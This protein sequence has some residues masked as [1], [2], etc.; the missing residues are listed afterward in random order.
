M[1]EEK[2]SREEI[3]EELKAQGI[4]K[5]NKISKCEWC[6]KP[7]GRK[8]GNQKTCSPECSRQM[9]LKK[10]RERS[11]KYQIKKTEQ[12][13]QHPQP[14]GDFQLLLETLQ[15]IQRELRI[16]NAHDGSLDGKPIIER[17]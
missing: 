16:R 15:G 3:I 2:Y 1:D 5:T 9:H 4:L 7:Y 14:K 6:G 17:E 11:Y 10:M 8:N 13:T 12:P